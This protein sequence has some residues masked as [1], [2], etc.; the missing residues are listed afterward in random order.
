MNN[1]RYTVIYMGGFELPDKNAAAQRVLGNAKAI[2]DIGVNVVLVGV[3]ND[4]SSDAVLSTQKDIQGFDCYEVPYP[5]GT[6][7]WVDYLINPH[8]YIDVISKYNNTKCVIFYNFQSISM[9]RII[10][11]CHKRGIKCIADVTEWYQPGG[12]FIHKQLKSW[13]TSYRMNR[14]HFEC[15]GLIV[16]SRYLENYYKERVKLINIPPLIDMAEEKWKKASNQSKEYV[17]SYVG[18]PSDRKERLDLIIQSLEQLSLDENEKASTLLCIAGITQKEYEEMYHTVS[19]TERVR[20][21]GRV[22]HQEAL[23]IVGRSKWAIVIRNRTRVVEAG[24]PTKVVESLAC[25]VPVIANKFSNI[26]DYLNK[27]NS[28]LLEDQSRLTE[29]IS[30]A[31]KKSDSRVVDKTVFDYRNYVKTIEQFLEIVVQE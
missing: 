27:D 15:D 2:R 31:F 18:K 7:S 20:F 25:G 29:A 19:N 23:D 9:H 14:V 10:H 4:I 5:K 12:S 24:F 13:D 1:E 11:Y 16:I 3:S 22:P 6:R 21:V 26:E 28:I 8:H 17:F 30:E